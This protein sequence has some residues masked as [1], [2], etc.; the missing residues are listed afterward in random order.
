MAQVSIAQQQ[1]SSNLEKTVEVSQVLENNDSTSERH[2][3][4][5]VVANA[6]TKDVKLASDGKTVLIPQPSDDP[7]DVLNWKA[8]KKYRVLLSLV[9]ASLVRRNFC[10]DVNISLLLAVDRFRYYVGFGMKLT[11]VL[12]ARSKT[13]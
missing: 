11:M 12:A 3:D 7:D 2:G 9:V 6:G 8:G 1:E 13:C 4:F 5:R 10:E